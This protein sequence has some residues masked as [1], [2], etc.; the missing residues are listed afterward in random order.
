MLSKNPFAQYAARSKPQS[1]GW[2]ETKKRGKDD[3]RIERDK[4]KAEKARKDKKKKSRP[5]KRKTYFDET[6]DED[7]LGSFIVNDDIVEIMSSDNDDDR[8][9]REHKSNKKV[10]K[11]IELFADDRSSDSDL[12]EPAFSASKKKSKLKKKS[13][14]SYI[15]HTNSQS[16][17]PFQSNKITK[18][19][20]KSS[21]FQDEKK[22]DKDLGERLNDTFN[23][24]YNDPYEKIAIQ[25][26]LKMSIREKRKQEKFNDQFTIQKALQKSTK[27]KTKKRHIILVD[28]DSDSD[29]VSESPITTKSSSYKIESEDD[30]DDDNEEVEE[31]EE[32]S[33][34]E[35][36]SILETTTKLSKEILSRMS[37]WC[38]ETKS[39]KSQK[40]D[41]ETTG[42][43]FDGA[44]SLFTCNSEKHKL[45][46]QKDDVEQY[47]PSLKLADYQLLGIN[48]MALL[49]GMKFSTNWK[50]QSKRNDKMHVNG[51]LVCFILF[52]VQ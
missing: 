41:F 4:K 37:Q 2:L 18:S 32:A 30:S 31:Y 1:N 8:I 44:I 12:G 10:R 19:L 29:S 3:K 27:I 33:A 24:P 26:A 5:K 36:T 20:L 22:D 25:K 42:M 38:I 35:V 51:V 39:L 16:K 50:R 11:K 43:I 34:K 21:Y 6:D 14:E 13:K 45:L 47:C 48:W 28:S 17:T 23:D 40:Q 7:S 46:V 52:N 49:H 9:L 15:S